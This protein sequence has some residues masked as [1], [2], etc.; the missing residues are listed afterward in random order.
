MSLY[1]FSR[2]ENLKIF[3]LSLTEL[4][5]V[6]L[7]DLKKLLLF[8]NYRLFLFPC[9]ILAFFLFFCLIKSVTSHYLAVKKKSNLRIQVYAP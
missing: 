7:L 5:C 9:S 2:N 6:E 8:V 4:V 3:F 1:I